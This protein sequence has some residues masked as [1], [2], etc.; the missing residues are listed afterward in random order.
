VTSH[1]TH[2]V[3]VEINFIRHWLDAKYLLA[4]NG[5][6]GSAVGSGAAYLPDPSLACG[7]VTC[8]EVAAAVKSQSVGSG[9][10]SGED[11][12][13]RRIPDAGVKEI[14]GCRSAIGDIDVA[15]FIQCNA[16]EATVP[17]R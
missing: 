6:G 14:N 7:S 1:A 16:G 13:D 9:N 10:P 3:G 15:R 4:V 17:A 5:G 12:G 8:P 11:S 2:S